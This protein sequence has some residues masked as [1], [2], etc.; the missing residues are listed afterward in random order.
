M[1]HSVHS[2]SSSEP[3][4]L[5]VAKCLPQLLAA[6]LAATEVVEV[7]EFEEFEDVSGFGNFSPKPPITCTQPA[8]IPRVC[9]V[10]IFARDFGGN[11]NIF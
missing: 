11:Y 7:Q 9:T 6:T 2:D 8:A 4:A 1:L 10:I 5:P 3:L